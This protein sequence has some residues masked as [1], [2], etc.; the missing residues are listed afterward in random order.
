MMEIKK[1]TQLH[2]L[3]VFIKFPLRNRRREASSMH[4]QN[5]KIFS[6]SLSVFFFFFGGFFWECKS[7]HALNVFIRVWL[8][9][10]DEY[11]PIQLQ[12]YSKASSIAQTIQRR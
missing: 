1:E 11:R 5:L 8:R 2:A 9:K 6:L 4:R 7:L 3:L 10:N 12:N